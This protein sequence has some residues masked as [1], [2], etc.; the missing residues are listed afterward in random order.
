MK[1]TRENYEIWFLDYLDGSL[2]QDGREEVHLFLQNHPDLADGLESF[3]TVLPVDTGRIYPRKELLKRS[4][5]DDSLIL[6]NI[7]VAEME[8]DLTEEETIEFKNWLSKNPDKQGNISL[9]QRI[10]LQP[11]LSIVFPRKEHLKKRPAQITLLYRITAVAALLLLAFLLYKPSLQKQDS[12]QLSANTVLPVEKVAK[13]TPENV[14]KIHV[15]Q[16]EKNLKTS[17][18]T[19]VLQKTAKVSREAAP[20]P[21]F[22]GTRQAEPIATLTTRTVTVQ[23]DLPAFYD[24]VPVRLEPVNYASGEIP[25]S[26]YYDI[27]FQSLKDQGPKGFITR[28]EVAVA[29]LRFFSRL[30]GNHLT[31][32]KG[33]NGNLETISFNSQPLAISI[34]LNR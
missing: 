32:K 23:T 22:S 31:G 24:L 29:G 9:I 27:K 16:A 17:R 20:E 13:P 28:E 12:A 25:L 1:I 3:P 30:T 5:Y 7:A 33:K 15:L 18:A 8:G 34:P 26:E 14:K 2:D 11:D 10:R 6:E 19:P 4:Q 21:A